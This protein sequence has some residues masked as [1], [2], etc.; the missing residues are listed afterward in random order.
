L[1]GWR[2]LGENVWAGGNELDLI[3]RRGRKL[4]FVDH[5]LAFACVRMQHQLRAVGGGVERAARIYARQSRPHRWDVRLGCSQRVHHGHQL[6][7]RHALRHR[8]AHVVHRGDLVR[9]SF[10]QLG[11]AKRSFP[12]GGV[13]GFQALEEPRRRRVVAATDEI[14]PGALDRPCGARRVLAGRVC[15]RPQRRHLPIE[16]FRPPRRGRV[17]VDVTAG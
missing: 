16:S 12:F 15:G 5:R 8:H 1:R 10:Q 2:I 7:V 9:L 14:S 13:C 17:Q 4:R 6:V 3:V 11:L